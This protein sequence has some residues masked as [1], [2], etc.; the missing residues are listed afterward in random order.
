LCRLLLERNRLGE[1]E[2]AHGHA[3]AIR[4]QLVEAEPTH[5]DHRAK[6]AATHNLL[7]NLFFTK[8]QYRQAE[9]AYQEAL[10]VQKQ[11]AQDFPRVS[12]YRQELA[13]T[14][15]NL[16]KA[17]TGGGLAELFVSQR[18]LAQAEP[19][20]RAAIALQEKLTLDFPKVPIYAAELGNSY[21]N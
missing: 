15:N 13:H 16:T 14:H 6:L 10:A 8:R 12:A 7:G 1:A 21:V 2:E 5:A 9:A 11:L 20:A 4:R 19:E 17:I 18:Q 3:L